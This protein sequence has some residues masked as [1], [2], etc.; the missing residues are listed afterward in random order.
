MINGIV[1]ATGP[2]A[3]SI[4]RVVSYPADLSDEQR[5]AIDGVQS[6]LT[7]SMIAEDA[8]ELSDAFPGI[9][10]GDPYRVESALGVFRTSFMA[11][12]DREYPGVSDTPIRTPRCGIVAVCAAVGVAAI[13]LG[14]AIAVVTFNVAGAINIIYNQNG[15]WNMNGTWNGKK[16]PRASNPT[17][18]IQN[19]PTLSESEEVRRITVSLRTS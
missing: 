8:R 9:T 3:E 7:Q 10:S 1:F 11:A 17:E 18:L 6:R 13:A 12:L 14:A 5:A 19:Y 4:E 16:A 2:V 15:L